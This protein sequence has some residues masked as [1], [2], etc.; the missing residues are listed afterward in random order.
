MT[1]NIWYYSNLLYNFL[2][3][4]FY[5]HLIN[6]LQYSIC[7]FTVAVEVVTPTISF[8]TTG[9][10]TT[11][12]QTMYL[13]EIIVQIQVIITTATTTTTTTTITILTMAITT[14]QIIQNLGLIEL[15]DSIL[16]LHQEI[17]R[18]SIQNGSLLS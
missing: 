2:F 13:L 18:R 14:T 8:L 9:P 15:V 6:Y 17:Y 1:I 12:L 10:Q 4:S 16:L 11:P 7:P 3:A 5:L